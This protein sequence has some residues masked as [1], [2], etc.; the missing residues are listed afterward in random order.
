MASA[1]IQAFLDHELISR[2]EFAE[3]SASG[4]TDHYRIAESLF[5]KAAFV[6]DRQKIGKLY[7]DSINTAHIHLEKTLFQEAAL[8]RL[9]K[10][11]ATNIVCIPIYIF[12][13]TLTVALTNPTDKNVLE[14][15]EKLTGMPVSPVFAF[16]SEILNS[17]EIQYGSP[18]DIEKLAEA[19]DAHEGMS[20]DDLT[21]FS[22]SSN[23][24]SLVT[25]ILTL[26]LKHGA[27]D[28]HIQPMSKKVKVR[29][30]I[31]GALQD[32]LELNTACLAPIVARL[33][34]LA[35][36]DITERRHP[37]D[38]R[39]ELEIRNRIFSFRLSTIPTVFGE[40]VVLRA[41][42]N[43]ADAT[44]TPIDKLNFSRSNR[45]IL[46]RIIGSPNG[47]LFVTGPTGSGKTTTLY[48]ILDQ[49][50]DPS[51]NIVTVED[52]VEIRLDG[53]SQIQVNAAIG[54]DFA[55]A[56]RSI[57]RQDPE[58]ILVGEI[59]DLE[60][61]KIA[62]EA[63]LTGHL[64]M[65][66]MHTNNALQAVTR[67]VEIGVAPFLVAPSVI[68]VVAQRLVRKICDNCKEAYTPDRELLE[69]LF[70]NIGDTKVEFYR[71]AGCQECNGSGYAGRIA[72]HEIFLVNETVRDMISK[73]ASTTDIEAESRRS[74]FKSLRYDGVMKVLQG[75]TTLEEVNKVVIE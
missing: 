52:P 12:G 2:Q 50:R 18:A 17:I 64:V 5:D 40:K 34:V 56:L 6:S 35:K 21:R 26:S 43:S 53:I 55:K 3:L 15:V 24:I 27:S 29:Y 68:G 75:L 20:T 1:L 33:K 49:M 39:L 67:L 65:A 11:F 58:V 46:D 25:G 59:R 71:G 10:E 23:I 63:A 60:T 22:S 36:L 45:K 73:N 7:G 72:L 48:S 13:D 66:T 38:G 16:A 9:D 42:G 57:L 19:M 41:L 30:R 8:A 74:G 54:F 61:A 69:S 28:I 62:A 31:D 44:V 51:T 47:V 14:K 70:H 37:Q 4:V 32:L